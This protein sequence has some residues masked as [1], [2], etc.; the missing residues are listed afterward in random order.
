MFA[1]PLCP[2]LSSHVYTHAPS[3]GW[4]RTVHSLSRQ[5]AS[6]AATQ[7]K[8]HSVGCAPPLY[9][10]CLLRAPLQA[11]CLSNTTQHAFYNSL[12]SSNLPAMQPRRAG[13]S[14]CR[15]PTR[16]TRP[17]MAASSG[18]TTSATAPPRHPT[19]HGRRCPPG[20]RHATCCRSP[21][22]WEQQQRRAH[23][24]A[25][26]CLNMS[27]KPVC[28]YVCVAGWLATYRLSK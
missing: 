14:S 19:S 13:T 7:H 20:A 12:P 22:R 2:R 21:A 16:T 3:G 5:L 9:L 26:G 11:G 28:V 15:S 6:Q 24:P 18:R 10:L 23:A 17:P 25:R 27:L 8:Q 1:G 4:V